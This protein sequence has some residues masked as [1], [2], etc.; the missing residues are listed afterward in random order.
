LRC[1]ACGELPGTMEAARGIYEARWEHCPNN[2]EPAKAKYT[3]PGQNQMPWKSEGMEP[4]NQLHE[5]VRQDWLS[6]KGQ[7]FEIQFKNKMKQE[8]G[9]APSRKRKTTKSVNVGCCS[10]TRRRE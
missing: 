5:E 3:N 10:W 7:R 8:A 6:S 4:Y 1:S 2:V 9:V